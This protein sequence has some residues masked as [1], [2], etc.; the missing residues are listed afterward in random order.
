[1]TRASGASTVERRRRIVDKIQEH[2]QVFI[3]ELSQQFGVSE[4]TIRND[5]DQLEA[6]KMLIRA[7]GG[8]INFEGYV[9][10]DPQIE[11]KNQLNYRQKALI[12]RKAAQLIKEGDTIILDSGTTT[13]EIVQHIP[14]FERLNIITNALNIVR[15]L[16]DHPRINVIIPGGYLRQNAMSLVGPLAERNLRSLYVDKV[17]LSADGFDTR[18]GI[19]TP[20]IDESHLNQIMIEVA[21][22]VILVT[23]SSKFKRKSLA[24]ICPVEK[25]DTVVTDNGISA[26][27][28]QRLENAGVRVI[29]AS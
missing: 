29:I 9:G 24:F 10:I 27:D 1:M 23:D 7:R 3:Q 2:G 15:L 28:K 14:S 11:Q 16:M 20:N 8:A 6:K 5:L 26:E 17:F 4:V 21:K 22:E 25:L 19:F 18:Q 13:S 12:G